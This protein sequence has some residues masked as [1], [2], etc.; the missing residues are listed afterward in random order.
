MINLI[1][2]YKALGGGWHIE[3]HH[4]PHSPRLGGGIAD[5]HELREVVPAPAPEVHAPGQ[6]RTTNAA[7]SRTPTSRIVQQQPI[8]NPAPIFRHPATSEE[9][10]AAFGSYQADEQVSRFRPPPLH[11]PVNRMRQQEPA[12]VFDVP[13]FDKSAFSGPVIQTRANATPSSEP[14]AWFVG[15]P[16]LIGPGEGSLGP[17]VPAEGSEASTP[18]IVP[19]PQDVS[20]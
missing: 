2:L 18:T 20:D 14:A 13:K 8:N 16:S 1:T 7:V 19:I 9:I 5:Y 3:D 10:E 11:Q 15:D 6:D 12:K 4:L 17:I